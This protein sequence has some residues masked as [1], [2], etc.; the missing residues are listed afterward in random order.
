MVITSEHYLLRKFV[1]LRIVGTG[2]STLVHTVPSGTWNNQNLIAYIS[3]GAN[4]QV[5]VNDSA[6]TGSV[7]SPTNVTGVTI[8]AAQME[9][10]VST[11][12]MQEVI[13]YPSISYKYI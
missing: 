9:M 2:G 7:A 3:D 13:V 11:G 1:T 5:G 4:S 12:T 8:G 10:L 6:T